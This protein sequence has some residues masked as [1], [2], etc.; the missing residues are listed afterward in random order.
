MQDKGELWAFTME[1]G[2]DGRWRIS[3]SWLLFLVG[4][5]GDDKDVGEVG[6]RAVDD[7]DVG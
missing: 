3:G 6:D 5:V 2:G 4:D 7:D 1:T